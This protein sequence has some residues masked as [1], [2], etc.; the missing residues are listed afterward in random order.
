MGGELSLQDTSG[1][2]IHI[3]FC[4]NKCPYCDFNSRAV[5]PVPEGSYVNA[6]IS[7]LE[8][9]IKQDRAAASKPLDTIYIGGGTP[10]LIS[11]KLIYRLLD[12]LKKNFTLTHNIEVTIEINPAAITQDTLKR[13]TDSGINRISIGIQSFNNH[14]LNKLGRLHTAKDG[15]NAY[16]CA[17]RAGFK[18]IGIDLMFAVPAQSIEVWKADIETAVKLTPEHI[19]IYGL[20][21]EEG[22]QFYEI[23]QKGKLNPPDEE[24]YLAMYESAVARLK[25]AGY[26]HYEISNLSLSGFESRHN[27]R[28]W[29]G[30]DYIGLG[31][32]AHSYFSGQGWG[33]RTWNEKDI[34][35][36]MD[37]VKGFKGARAYTEILTPQQA[38]TEYMFLGLRLMKGIDKKDFY[39][40]FGMSPENK[41]GF[42]LDRLKQENL[43]EVVQGSIR[44]TSKGIVLSDTVAGNL[45]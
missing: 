10:S 27:M 38:I 9:I 16:E 5:Y 11:P 42:A 13:Y 3:P 18:N 15:L 22:T 19:S 1:I 34:S 43:L 28:Y 40:R 39:K 7:E 32:G 2:Y 35:L 44:L 45:V 26:I 6:L 17:R 31:P 21:I 24:T 33:R 23:F 30:F 14:I 12:T 41:F 25:Q 8:F 20:T 36:Y 37:R 4:K 29:H